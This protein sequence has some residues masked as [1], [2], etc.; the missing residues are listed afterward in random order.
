MDEYISFEQLPFGAD[1]FA[2]N[3]ESR[4]PCMLLLDTSGSM[5]GEPIRQLNEGINTLKMEL[6]LDPLAAKRVEVAMVTFGPVSYESDF[7]TVDNFYPKQLVAS[8]DTPIGAAIRL[9]IDLVNKRKKL[10]K[11][12]GVGYY[13]PW[14]ILITDGA[15]TDAW[16]LAAQLVR[17]GESENRFA[18]FAIGVEGANFDVLRQL[19][20][21]APLKLRGLAF[22]EF[23][24][25]LSGSLK[26]VSSKNPG[27]NNK[28]LPPTGWADL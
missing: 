3:P 12:R 6:E 22:R 16:S 9:G 13:K 24:L 5:G 26:T 25:W 14:I 10:Y 27:E 23:F 7:Q 18:F 1:D 15:P 8:G 11:E 4:C 2:D 17:E 20:V 28:L 19:S 21:R